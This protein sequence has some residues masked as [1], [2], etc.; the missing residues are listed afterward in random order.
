MVP[1]IRPY[2][3]INEN[4]IW[5]VLDQSN[6]KFWVVDYVGNRYGIQETIFNLLKE[7]GVKDYEIK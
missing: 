2:G 3:Y 5:R 1:I 6:G 7:R 4:L